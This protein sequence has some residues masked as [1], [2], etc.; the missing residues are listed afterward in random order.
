VIDLSPWLFSRPLGDCYAGL[1]ASPSTV[2]H[3]RFLIAGRNT[4]GDNRETR[5]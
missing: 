3:S 4:R 5:I 1:V 2:S